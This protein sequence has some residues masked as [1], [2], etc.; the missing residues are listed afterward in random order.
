MPRRV[1]VSLFLFHVADTGVTS[2]VV[3]ASGLAGLRASSSELRISKL[4]FDAAQ[5][6]HCVAVHPLPVLAVRKRGLWC[7]GS[8]G[9]RRVRRRFG[10]ASRARAA[11]AFRG[12]S[13]VHILLLVLLAPLSFGHGARDLRFE[14]GRHVREALLPASIGLRDGGVHFLTLPSGNCEVD[15]QHLY[16][17]LQFSS[18]IVCTMAT[19]AICRTLRRCVD[20]DAAGR[21][22]SK[23]RRRTR[24]SAGRLR[25]GLRSSGAVEHAVPRTVVPPWRP[26]RFDG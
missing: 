26:K 7:G 20:D 22:R 18:T 21:A 4:A 8:H 16:L 15:T 14:G 17:P 9:S 23:F 13:V 25:K 19:L 2:T 24:R 10:G 11:T 1:E 5:L 12:D 6:P 3:M